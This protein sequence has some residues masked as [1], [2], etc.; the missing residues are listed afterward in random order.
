[1]LHRAEWAWLHLAGEQEALAFAVRCGNVLQL[2]EVEK[3]LDL[4]TQGESVAG[5]QDLSHLRRALSP[6]P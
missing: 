4:W 1:M 5:Q 6:E 2:Q 3:N